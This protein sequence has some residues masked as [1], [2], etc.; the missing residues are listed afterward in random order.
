MQPKSTQTGSHSSSEKLVVFVRYY[1]N[2]SIRTLCVF[3]CVKTE[4]VTES[5]LRIL[6]KMLK[7][8]NSQSELLAG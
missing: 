5:S 1:Q 4:K 8:S 3:M 6:R 2:L 7:V